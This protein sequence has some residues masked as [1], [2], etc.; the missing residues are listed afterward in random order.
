MPLDQSIFLKIKSILVGSCNHSDICTF[1]FHPLK[2]ITTG[3]EGL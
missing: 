2:T 1:S 3:G